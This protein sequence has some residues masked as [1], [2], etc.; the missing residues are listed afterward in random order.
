[1][2]LAAS[3]LR[4]G[5]MY[6]YTLAFGDL[7]SLV[8]FAEG[9]YKNVPHHNVPEEPTPLLVLLFEM[10]FLNE[11]NNRRHM[12]FHSFTYKPLVSFSCLVA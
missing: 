3:S 7:T 10:S 1:M 6:H 12:S 4:L 8:N 11:Y 2:K 9:W 5:R